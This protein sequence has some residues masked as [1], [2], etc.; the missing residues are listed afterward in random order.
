MSQ[1]DVA[2]KH[3]RLDEAD[4]DDEKVGYWLEKA[5]EQGDILTEKVWEMQI[6]III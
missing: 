6:P 2:I 5:A 3:T 1:L 4:R